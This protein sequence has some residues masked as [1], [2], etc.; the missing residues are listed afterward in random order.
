M[1]NLSR[2]FQQVF[3]TFEPPHPLCYHLLAKGNLLCAV[4]SMPAPPPPLVSKIDILLPRVL[5][6]SLPGMFAV[7]DEA[8]IHRKCA[9]TN[10]KQNSFHVL[11]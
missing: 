9:K 3:G 11:G 2:L 5:F 10:F 6:E 7:T 8:R 4:I 1:I